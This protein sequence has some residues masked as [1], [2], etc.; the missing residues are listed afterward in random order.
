[1]KKKEAELMNRKDPKTRPTVSFYREYD[2]V[3][4]DASAIGSDK[5]RIKIE[6]T[7]ELPNKGY[8]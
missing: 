7:R 6:T 3:G 1:M 2:H 5:A 4:Y 8:C